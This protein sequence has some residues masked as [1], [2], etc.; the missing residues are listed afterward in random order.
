MAVPP[1]P[2][3]KLLKKER[4]SCGLGIIAPRIAGLFRGGEGKR[5][6]P[7]RAGG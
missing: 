3:S 2:E 7:K 6:G 4:R 1:S 5:V